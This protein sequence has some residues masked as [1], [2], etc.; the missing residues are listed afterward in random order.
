MF[1]GQSRASADNHSTHKNDAC[2]TCGVFQVNCEVK[3]TETLRVWSERF[4]ATQAPVDKAFHDHVWKAKNKDEVE[5]DKAETPLQW[6]RLILYPREDE[7]K[8]FFGEAG[9]GKEH[10]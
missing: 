8:M 3:S 9:L 7:L 2:P 1:T 5:N 4:Y 6:H 10:A